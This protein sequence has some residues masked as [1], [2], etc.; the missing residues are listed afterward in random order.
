V[1]IEPAWVGL[2][3]KE[4]EYSQFLREIPFG[5]KYLVGREEL[6]NL[7]KRRQIIPQEEIVKPDEKEIMIPSFP[8]EP[9][10]IKVREPAIR[11]EADL[12]PEEMF[13]L[14]FISKN[15]NTF[16]TNIYKALNLSGYK[17]DRLKENLIEKGL[18]VQEETREGRGGRLAKVLLLTV[19]GAA[20]LKKAPVAGKGGDLHKYLQMTIKEQAELLGWKATIEEKILKSLETVDVGLRKND[21]LV[22]VEISS[23]SKADQEIQ[24]IR[25]CLE[26]GY[27]Y[28]ISVLSDE[29]ALSSL[30]KEA[31]KG[32]HH[33]ER[34]RIR[35]S[36]PDQVRDIIQGVVSEKAVVSGQISKEKQLLDTTEASEFLGIK[37]N[38]LYEWIIQKK[39]PHVKVGRLVKFRKADLE[40]W[41][42]KRTQDVD[43]RE[44]I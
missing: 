36:L 2:G 13:L 21:I 22:A 27:D 24:N 26:A 15:P 23:T 43:K 1:E 31:R 44:Y 11:G 12:T 19:K 30:K 7:A 14:D 18:I 3:M 5:R 41:L 29:K 17:G 42:T 10:K 25:K 34:E 38:T 9:A 6:L 28:V 20:L 35:F 39:V 8:K 4:Q 33:R 40:E 37:K 16:V 32:F